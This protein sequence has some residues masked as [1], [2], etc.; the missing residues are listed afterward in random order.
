[1][2]HYGRDES[3]ALS[4]I[5]SRPINNSTIYNYD[6]SSMHIADA[7]AD[8][9]ADA[10]GRASTN[11]EYPEVDWMLDSG[12]YNQNYPHVDD[13]VAHTEVMPMPD[14]DHNVTVTAANEY[15]Y[16]YEYGYGYDATATTTTTGRVLPDG[17]GMYGRSRR[18][19]NRFGARLPA[20]PA[21]PATNK[22]RMLPQAVAYQQ[23]VHNAQYN[24]NMN[25]GQ[26]GQ[27][28]YAPNAG[29]LDE[30][31]GSFISLPSAAAPMRTTPDV[32]S[33]S[34]TGTSNYEVFCPMTRPYTSMLP[35]DYSDYDYDYAAHADNLS[36][37][38]DTPPMSNAQHKL[39]QQRK[40]SLMMAMT[41]ASVIA[42]GETRVPVAVPNHQQQQQQQRIINNYPISSVA[43]TEINMLDYSVASTMNM[44]I[45]T[46]TTTARKLPKRLPS[47]QYK[48]SL[49][50]TT[51]SPSP[52]QSESH[53]NIN[54]NTNI[55]INALSLT[56]SERNH[57][58]KQLPKLP[59]AKT[60]VTE[61]ANSVPIL[62]S[63]TRQPQQQQQQQ[64]H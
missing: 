2:T 62:S 55:N 19:D 3:D 35:L 53:T 34:T 6:D 46:T 41:T 58:P 24:D 30:R 5:H 33:T 64:Q 48:S 22:Y 7:D 36:T 26:T 39:Q 32:P 29:L 23:N 27:S 20:A 13:Y 28:G 49:Y 40:I 9:D 45:T 51:T 61:N 10:Y 11:T 1:M 15:D 12:C 63:T 18:G 57:R 56:Q 60:Q 16:G 38:S 31:I 21:A 52:S 43:T 42:S 47:P 25:N 44:N 59:M 54:T 17:E 37:Y 50:T 14:W 4:T 8:A